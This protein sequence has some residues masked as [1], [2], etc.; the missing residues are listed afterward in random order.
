LKHAAQRVV[1]CAALLRMIASKNFI[2]I[3]PQIWAAFPIA[4]TSAAARQS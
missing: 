1:G 2:G 4:K 3:E